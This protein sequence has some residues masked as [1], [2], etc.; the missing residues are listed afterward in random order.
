VQVA[1]TEYQT[2]NGFNTTG[3][4][5]ATGLGVGI[6]PVYSNSKFI[7]HITVA[8]IF[9]WPAAGSYTNWSL[10]HNQS[11]TY[12]SGSNLAYASNYISIDG[13]YRGNNESNTFYVGPYG[14][15]ATQSYTLYAC[16]INGTVQFNRDS[17]S[18]STIMVI[19][20]KQ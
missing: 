3:G 18:S 13:T 19:E 17:S 8:G 20:V 16:P 6:N 10:R 4:F 1:Y 11:G 9:Q 15:T 12:V 7:I 14:T 2:E 5:Q